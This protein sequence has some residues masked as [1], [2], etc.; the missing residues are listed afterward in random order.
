MAL[1]SH[2]R[3]LAGEYMAQRVPSN[4]N[5]PRDALFLFRFLNHVVLSHGNGLR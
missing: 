4:A 5:T 1:R 2:V 3:K